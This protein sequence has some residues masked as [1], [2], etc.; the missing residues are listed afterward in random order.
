MTKLL[1]TALG[2]ACL[3]LT[4]FSE[5]AKPPLHL[6][7]AGL[8]HDHAYGFLPRLENRTDVQLV[9]I[10]ETNQDLIAR[11]SK[12]FHL[13]PGLFCASLEELFART[14]VEAV[15]TFTSVYDHAGVVQICAAHKI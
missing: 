6:A 2:C 4:G 15:A 3:G 7:M 9:G 14:N 11:Y 13:A 5:D 8:E 12:R 1:L 10:V